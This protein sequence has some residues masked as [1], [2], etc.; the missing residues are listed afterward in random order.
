VES[1]IT[2]GPWFCRD[3]DPGDVCLA[4]EGLT[5]HSKVSR[6]GGRRA[7]KIYSR[8]ASSST[9]IRPQL[10]GHAPSHASSGAAKN[11]VGS[12]SG[13]LGYQME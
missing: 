13:K 2:R 3:P 1:T 6:S 7:P 11:E 4:Q 10:F 12:M 8:R 9:G 5:V